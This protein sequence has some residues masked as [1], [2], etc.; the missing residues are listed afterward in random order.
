MPMAL[1]ADV[2]LQQ[3]IIQKDGSL[4]SKD[5]TACFDDLMSH[6][7]E[8]DHAEGD[9]IEQGHE[10]A[11]GDGAPCVRQTQQVLTMDRTRSASVDKD[12]LHDGKLANA[13]LPFYAL[14]KSAFHARAGPLYEHS[15]L[16]AHTLIKR[17]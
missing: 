8:D 7:Q 1:A 9:H 6:A 4:M 13:V 3:E 11:C 16:L 17:E 2:H 15:S 10:S 14:S 5:I 12:V